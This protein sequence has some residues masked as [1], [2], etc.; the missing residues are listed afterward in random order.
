ME[1]SIVQRSTEAKSQRHR[2]ARSVTI[3]AKMRFDATRKKFSASVCSGPGWCVS[4]RTIITLHELFYSVNLPLSSLGCAHLKSIVFVLRETLMA[5]TQSSD[6]DDQSND[7]HFP[8][9]LRAV[10]EQTKQ[11][12]PAPSA[13]MASVAKSVLPAASVLNQESIVVLDSVKKK[14]EK[15]Q[16]VHREDGFDPDDN[17][18]FGKKWTNEQQVRQHLISAHPEYQFII[19][20]SGASNRNLSTFYQKEALDQHSKRLL[21]RAATADAIR[22]EAFRS[23]S[24]AQKS[25]ENLE[26]AQVR[27]DADLRSLRS[28]ISDLNVVVNDDGEV[29][30]PAVRQVTEQS[31]LRPD[32]VYENATNG[33]SADQ[34]LST[35]A[36]CKYPA[37]G[38]DSKQFVGEF[39]AWLSTYAVRPTIFRPES[40]EA[41]RARDN[42]PTYITVAALVS[43][44]YSLSHNPANLKYAVQRMQD[45]QLFHDNS[46]YAQSHD[47]FAH[48][49]LRLVSAMTENSDDD[50]KFHVSWEYV[51]VNVYLALK[52]IEERWYPVENV[53]PESQVCDE[54]RLSLQRPESG[55]T[56]RSGLG[57][58]SRR[59]Q[60]EELY[61]YGDDEDDAELNKV[62]RKRRRV[63]NS[64]DY[65]RFI[66]QVF[67]PLFEHGFSAL[68]YDMEKMKRAVCDSDV[69]INDVLLCKEDSEKA[70][71][72]L[73][74]VQSTTNAQ[75]TSARVDYF[76]GGVNKRDLDIMPDVARQG[77]KETPF[78]EFFSAL[79]F[80]YVSAINAPTAA[81]AI[82][83]NQIIQQQEAIQEEETMQS[84][85]AGMLCGRD[86]LKNHYKLRELAAYQLSGAT[87]LY[88]Q[89]VRQA[90]ASRRILGSLQST[91]SGRIIAQEL[92]G[93]SYD[94]EL[95]D[96]EE[97]ALVSEDDALV[98]ES[99]RKRALRKIIQKMAGSITFFN[100]KLTNLIESLQRVLGDAREK[101]LARA[102]QISAAQN[103][104][105]EQLLRSLSAQ[106]AQG[107]ELREAQIGRLIDRLKRLISRTHIDSVEWATNP[108]NTGVVDLSP[109]YIAAVEMAYVF[110]QRTAPNL[111]NCTL[112]DLKL[113]PSLR[114]VFA[115]VV[116]QMLASTESRHPRSLQLNRFSV[117]TLRN[118]RNLAIRLR[119]LEPLR[120]AGTG[121]NWDRSM[122]NYSGTSDIGVGPDGQF[123]ARNRYVQHAERHFRSEY[124]RER[125]KVR[126]VQRRDE[127]IVPSSASFSGDGSAKKARLY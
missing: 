59:I 6:G 43:F 84:L 70:L 109:Q 112:D 22:S 20:V 4:S 64:S 49:V 18:Y 65:R 93:T 107:E 56:T 7:I 101:S 78:E 40:P 46:T 120:T 41:A 34:V 39:L 54:G 82:D 2:Y 28:A 66:I 23:V 32:G 86:S 88:A 33:S 12:Q 31:A 95:T 37:E 83:N 25:I 124:D 17:S 99:S 123:P 19:L 97:Q 35:A 21:Q 89:F 8:A 5:T 100:N 1:A 55:R 117:D 76:F 103:G 24:E 92:D 42:N 77:V 45:A 58:G 121:T 102:E 122:L 61:G 125:R 105:R 63:P 38:L 27:T 113:R 3:H 68:F 115:E 57:N 75:R 104:L 118:G 110:V 50:A 87:D 62:R 96:A 10:L 48:D 26:S 36:R 11:Q 47:L 119:R 80:I 106:G 52:C 9:A 94:T 72:K 126:Q 13:S 73:L 90:R 85:R 81:H 69:R 15:F 67:M 53:L 29:V 71:T 44:L 116:A 74:M 91:I 98:N 79:S 111:A 114:V 51:S 127:I 108:Q 16:G 60:D 14:L 30:A